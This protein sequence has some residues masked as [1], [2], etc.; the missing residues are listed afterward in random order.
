MPRHLLDSELHVLAGGE[1]VGLE[2]IP[3]HPRAAAHAR[4]SRGSQIRPATADAATNQ[5]TFKLGNAGEDSKDQPAVWRCCVYLFVQA[6][7]GN[8]QRIKFGQRVHKLA[9]VP[10]SRAVSW[11]LSEAGA[12]SSETFAAVCLPLSTLAAMRRSSSFAPVHAPM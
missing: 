2:V 1:H 10:S 8:S 11:S 5:F 6:Y 9:S 4:N 3:E 12:R 7:E